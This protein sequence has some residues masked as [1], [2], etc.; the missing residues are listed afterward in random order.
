MPGTVAFTLI[1]MLVVSTLVAVLVA[2]LLPGLAQTKA[3]ARGVICGVRLRQ[4]GLATQLYALEHDD[5]LPPE[6][7][8][9]PNDRNTNF[10]W[11]IQL[12]AQIGIE[13]YHSA[14]WRTNANA[15]VGPT[16]W[17]C[18]SNTRRS[19][20]R[21][22]FHYCLNQHVDGASENDAPARLASIP[23]SSRTVWLFDSK[24]LPAV[25]YWGFTHTN[26]HQRGAQFLFLDGHAERF[27]AT[28]YWDFERNR[29]R[30]NNPSLV[31]IP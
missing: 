18:P 24:N 31:W 2:L 30:T 17:L 11:Y 3:R 25:G 27:P 22:L 6:G 10:G 4:W 16:V 9:N 5:F 28:A 13:P 29:G 26:L 21:N 8:P 20:G 12:P 7:F 23:I 19:N 15:P 14:P 1:E